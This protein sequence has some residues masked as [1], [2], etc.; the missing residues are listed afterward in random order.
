MKSNKTAL[1]QEPKKRGRPR[2]DKNKSKATVPEETTIKKLKARPSAS[3]AISRIRVKN[4]PVRLVCPDRLPNRTP[5]MSMSLRVPPSVYNRLNK[6]SEGYISVAAWA[7]IE[8]GLNR[9]DASNSTWVVDL[10]IKE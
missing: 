1:N 10:S 9:L 4:G 8:D 2:L 7:L 6:L 5:T 3:G